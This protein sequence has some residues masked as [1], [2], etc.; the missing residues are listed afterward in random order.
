MDWSQRAR[1]LA[2]TAN[3]GGGSDARLSKANQ[4]NILPEA[5]RAWISAHGGRWLLALGGRSS[6]ERQVRFP[7]A[8]EGQRS[9][10]LRPCAGPVPAPDPS[11][12][13]TSA[14]WTKLKVRD[15]PESDLYRAAR[16]ASCP[17]G[18]LRLLVWCRRPRHSRLRWQSRL[19]PTPER[20][21]IR[22]LLP[23]ARPGRAECRRS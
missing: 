23:A 20:R 1:K 7:A 4:T 16:L 6:S 21:P 3:K 8:C 11:R 17:A 12:R 5:S 2:V 14:F 9:T 13:R 10:Y 18:R 19:G 22:R 15:R